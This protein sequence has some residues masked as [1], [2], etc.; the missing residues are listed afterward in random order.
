MEAKRTWDESDP[1]GYY[2]E[3]REDV[4][5]EVLDDSFS[6]RSDV[7]FMRNM[8]DTITWSSAINVSWG[9]LIADDLFG[10]IIRG[11]TTPAAVIEELDGEIQSIIDATYNKNKK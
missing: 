5:E 8:G 4:I 9:P 10:A 3:D 11:D 7:E 2:V 6:N 1:E